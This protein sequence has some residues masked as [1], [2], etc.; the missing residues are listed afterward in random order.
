MHV[1][2]RQRNAKAMP[3]KL[4]EFIWRRKHQRNPWQA[5]I[6]NLS[7]VSFDKDSSATEGQLV[8]LLTQVFLEDEENEE[9]EVMV[10]IKDK[11][12]RIK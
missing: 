10:V 8:S 1:P 7:E 4:I 3:W 6:K 2:Y 12:R 9:D 11:K 5:L